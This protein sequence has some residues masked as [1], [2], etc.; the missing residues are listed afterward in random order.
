MTARSRERGSHAGRPRGNGLPFTVPGL[1]ASGRCLGQ[2]RS[3]GPR[4][5]R[6]T[7]RSCRPSSRLDQGSQPTA[8]LARSRA[9]R[10]RYT[11][12]RHRAAP[13]RHADARRQTADGSAPPRRPSESR[14]RC[15]AR[16]RQ[17]A[18]QAAAR[19]TLLSRKQRMV[20]VLVPAVAVLGVG[21]TDRLRRPGLRGADRPGVPVR[22]GAGQVRAG[23]RAH[24]RR[25]PAR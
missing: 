21:F 3:D 23:G 5:S 18:P 11:S 2:A 22:L 24:Q 20:A 10:A 14:R 15:A 19:R 16:P 1:R 8:R 12:Q 7:S 9:W 13:R 17:P 6:R 4:R 25:A